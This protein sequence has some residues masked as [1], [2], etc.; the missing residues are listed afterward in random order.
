MVL[1]K[2]LGGSLIAVVQGVLFLLLT[3][4][5]GIRF[6]FATA[7]LLVAWLL[8]CAIGLTGLGFVIAWRMDSTQGFH[9]VM[10]LLLMP[11]WLLSG[12][13][14]PIPSLAADSGWVGLIMH[15]VMRLNPVTYAVAGLRRLLYRDMPGELAAVSGG[16]AIW[17]PGMDSCFLV[18][19]AFTLLTLV[20]AC[21]MAR[22][23]ASGDLL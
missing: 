19:A 17:V 22:Q 12:A 20:L 4:F 16:S 21:R 1:G 10:N 7:I 14:F 5:L 8:V 6:G 13:F 23:P 18:V 3:L 9:A 11:M 15:W 2:L